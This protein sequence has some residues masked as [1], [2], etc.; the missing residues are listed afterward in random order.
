M[1]ILFFDPDVVG[2]PPCCKCSSNYV[3][4]YPLSVLKLST[5]SFF[6]IPRNGDPEPSLLFA[7]LHIA[8]R[9]DI[10]TEHMGKYPVIFC[11]FKVRVYSLHTF[12]KTRLRIAGSRRELLG[13]NA[14][15]LPRL[16]FLPLSEVGRLP[17][18]VS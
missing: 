4:L 2:N 18:A 17:H 3:G 10:C 16:G 8:S 15:E 14:F 12:Q 7:G 5:R 1:L 11:D 6:S 13:G 9:Q